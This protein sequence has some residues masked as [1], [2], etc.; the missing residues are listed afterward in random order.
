MQEKSRQK[1]GHLP[2]INLASGNTGRVST[3]KRTKNTKGIVNRERDVRLDST[4]R[5][6]TLRGAPCWAASVETGQ[7]ARAN[8]QLF[9]AEVRP[10]PSECRWSRRGGILLPGDACGVE[11]GIEVFPRNTMCGHLVPLS[12]FLVRAQP[13]P[14]AFHVIIVHLRGQGCGDVSQGKCHVCLL[15]RPAVW[16]A[17]TCLSDSPPLHIRVHP[18]SASFERAGGSKS[19]VVRGTTGWTT[20]R[21]HE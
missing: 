9:R 6:I 11:R 12:T 10:C 13:G 4:A 17:I 14:P 20:F 2:S 7:T 21:I 5:V 8:K 16:P 19:R 3:T 1:N 15:V 18:A